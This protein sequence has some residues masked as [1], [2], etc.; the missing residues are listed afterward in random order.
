M[1]DWHHIDTVLLDM[2]GT[3]LD[4]A[5]DNW[6][7]LQHVPQEYARA[8]RMRPDEAHKLIAEWIHRH[9]GT[10]NLSLIHI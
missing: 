8:N 6:F 1:I 2:D 4:L 7:W 5:Y 3:L 9:H 10:L